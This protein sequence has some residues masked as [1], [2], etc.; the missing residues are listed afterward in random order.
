MKS[1][2]D[3]TAL[4]LT[5]SPGKRQRRSWLDLQPFV[6]DGTQLLKK[7]HDHRFH[8]RQ[9]ANGEWVQPPMYT[10]A[11]QETVVRRDRFRIEGREME[12]NLPWTKDYAVDATKSEARVSVEEKCTTRA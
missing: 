3:R 12:S 5:L 11:L 6:L 7:A 4:A 8:R 10:D 2:A 1:V 9:L